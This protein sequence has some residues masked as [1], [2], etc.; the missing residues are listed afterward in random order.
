VERVYTWFTDFATP[1]TLAVFG[2]E[3]IARWG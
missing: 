3:V 1:E 2:S